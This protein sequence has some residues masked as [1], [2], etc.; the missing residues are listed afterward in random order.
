MRII[1]PFRYLNRHGIQ[2]RILPERRLP[3]L[4]IT[5]LPPY[6]IF[7][8]SRRTPK[9]RNVQGMLDLIRIEQTRGI[10]VVYEIDDDP[11]SARFYPHPEDLKQIFTAVD[12]VIVSTH[13]LAKRI[14][15]YTKVPP[16]VVQNYIDGELWDRFRNFL[17]GNYDWDLRFDDAL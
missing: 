17:A 12:A 14:A 13:P 15:P 7:L 16:F 5:G 1:H 3:T 2:A 10:K 6:N 8:L 9:E 4:K 11:F